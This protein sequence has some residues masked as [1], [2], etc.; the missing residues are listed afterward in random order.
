[1]NNFR[2]FA[3]WI[4]IGMLL[5]SLFSLFQG[6]GMRSNA[7]DVSYSQ[8]L[9]KVNAGEIKSISYSGEGPIGTITST[10]GDGKTF[11]TVGPITEADLKTLRDKGVNVNFK[12]A[13][14]ESTLSN[15]LIYW[16]PMLVLVGVWVFFIRQMQAGSGKAMG[17]GKSKAKLLTEKHGRVTFADVAGVDE[18]KDDLVEIVDFL[19]DPG[20]FQRLGGK[21]PKG[22]LLVGPPGTG[23]TL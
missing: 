16:L 2:T 9:D 5:I 14:G 7:A 15:A 8:L 6:Q 18:A 19:K 11:S 21:I 17:F 3:I 12:A 22:A 23:K 4:I 10:T 13:G 20:K 1:M